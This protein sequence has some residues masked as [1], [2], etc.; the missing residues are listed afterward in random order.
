MTLVG[1]GRLVVGFG[2]GLE[3]SSD[4]PAAKEYT[5]RNFPIILHSISLFEHL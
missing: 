2:T 3:L 5:H 4:V 1:Q